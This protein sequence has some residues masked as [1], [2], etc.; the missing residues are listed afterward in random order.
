[1]STATVPNEEAENK[2]YIKNKK[3]NYLL[4]LNH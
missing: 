3:Y 4:F 2:Y 1:M